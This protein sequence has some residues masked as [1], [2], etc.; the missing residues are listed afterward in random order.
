MKKLFIILAVMAVVFGCTEQQH[1][2]LRQVWGLIEVNPESAK[3]VLA[4]VHTNSLTERDK[5]EYGLL[6]TILISKT[7][8]IYMV[9]GMIDNDSLISASIAYYNQ[10]GDEWHPSVLSVGCSA[11]ATVCCAVG[12]QE[13]NARVAIRRKRSLVCFILLICYFCCEVTEKGGESVRRGRKSGG[14]G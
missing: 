11:S 5:A 14:R 2:L 7:H 3:V 8:G 6:K 13:A 10:H 12:R 9:Y 4:K 1:P